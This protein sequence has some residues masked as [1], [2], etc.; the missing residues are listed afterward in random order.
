MRETCIDKNCFPGSSC[1]WP[2]CWKQ[3]IDGVG[4]HDSQNHEITNDLAGTVRSGSLRF[5]EPH[6][7]GHSLA[8]G[9]KLL[10][11]FSEA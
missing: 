8:Y 3:P 1:R 2:I 9:T 6:C 4:R 7:A 10:P 5:V 11:H